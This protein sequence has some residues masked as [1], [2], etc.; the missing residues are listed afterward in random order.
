MQDYRVRLSHGRN[1]LRVAWSLGV[2]GEAHA[3][4]LLLQCVPPGHLQQAAHVPQSHLRSPPGEHVPS[5]SWE[6]NWWGYQ[7]PWMLELC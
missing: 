2:C 3:T 7:D 6:F 5:S 4:E 1:K